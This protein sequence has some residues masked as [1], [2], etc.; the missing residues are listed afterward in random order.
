MAN[1]ILIKKNKNETAKEAAKIVSVL[2]KRKP[3]LVLSLS[4]GGTMIPFYKELIKLNKNKKVSFK[5]VRTFNLDEYYPINPKNKNSF[6]YYMNKNFFNKVDLDEKNINFFD[7]TK[8]D[9]K[10]ECS[11]Y[12]RKIK[13]VGGIDLQILGIGRNSHIAFNE[14]GSSFN[15]KT[16]KIKLTESTVKANSRFFKSEKEVPKHALTM[17]I[18]TILKAK[19][20]ILIATGKEKRECI[21]RTLKGKISKQV[22]ASILRKH[23]NTTFILDK[24]ASSS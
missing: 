1:T 3:N 5:K 15:S 22:P 10:K 8:R 21:R 24:Q 19:R 16:R 18:S 13:S 17:G 4:A 20:I 7:S 2:I 9:Y 14:P 6:R 23:K 11:N 12:E